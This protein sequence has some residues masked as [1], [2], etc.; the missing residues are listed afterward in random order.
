MSIRIR[1]ALG[2]ALQTAVVVL[3]VAAVQFLAL[4]SFLA[5]AEYERLE[6]LIPRLEQELAARPRSEAAPPLEITTLPRNVDVRVLQGGQVVAVTENFPP[7]PADLPPGYAPRAG[8]DV[9]IA[10]VTLRGGAATAQLASDVLGVVN[11]LRAYLRALAVTV[12]TAAALVALLSF[13]LAGRLLRPVA[14]LQEAAARLGQRGDLRS[15]LP[16]AGRNDELGR[17]AGT[18]QTSFAQLADVR[19]R[20]EEFTRAAAHDLR[21]PLAALKMRL[22]GSLAGPRSEA[23][24]RE[25]MAEALADVERMRRLTEHL[26]LLARGVRAVQLLPVDL[27]RVAGEAVDRA[28]EA[29]PDVRLDFETRGDATVIGDEALLTHLVENLIGNGLRY[30]QGADMRVS[31]GGEADHVRLTVQDAGPGVPETALPHLA[32]PFYQVNTARGGEGNGLGLAI[33][34]R[35]AQTHG[36]TLRFENGE[37]GGLR[38]AVDFPRTGTD[39]PEWPARDFLPSHNR[40]HSQ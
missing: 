23:E 28:R 9:L 34:Q 10:T 2:V 29:A 31:V 5:V 4:R 13:L 17:L 12:P 37:P 16:G 38:V 25:D 36:A 39:Q 26:L 22:Q 27:A 11:P 19:E 24:L 6:M 15:P 8:H 21:S 40:N 33:V 30:G 1:I 20:E 18:L 35:V 14:R 7:I 32:E 3:V